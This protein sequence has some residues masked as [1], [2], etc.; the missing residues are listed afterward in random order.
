MYW[1]DQQVIETALAD[2]AI[3]TFDHPVL[4]SNAWDSFQYSVSSSSPQLLPLK[5][6]VEIDKDSLFNGSPLAEL[7]RPEIRNGLKSGRLASVA[8]IESDILMQDSKDGWLDKSAE[9]SKAAIRQLPN[10]HRQKHV[11][12]AFRQLA[13]RAQHDQ[14]VNTEYSALS[15]LSELRFANPEDELRMGKILEQKDAYEHAID[16]LYRAAKLSGNQPRYQVA[17]GE[18]YLRIKKYDQALRKFDSVI[19]EFPQFSPS[20]SKDLVLERATLLKGVTLVKLQRNQEGQALIVSVLL[21]HP[22]LQSL[23]DRHAYD[24]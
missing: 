22:E 21:K 7:A 23:H 24:W 15:N 20:S 3:N 13:D 1:L 18:G 8:L 10:L 11:A 5:E 2:S 12:N 14:D 9:R 6:L 19:S 17:L 16:H 4:E